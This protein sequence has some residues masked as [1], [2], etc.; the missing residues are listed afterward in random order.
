MQLITLAL[1]ATSLSTVCLA[2]PANN[3]VALEP[4][5]TYIITCIGGRC[6]DNISRPTSG[7]PEPTT[8]KI[9]TTTSK[10]P[11]PP[12]S[13][14]KPEPTPTTTT[15]KPEP[16]KST[17]T[18]KPEPP[19]TSEKPEPTPTPTKTTIKTTTKS[20]EKPT[21]TTTE[22]VGPSSTRCPVPLYYKCGGWDGGVPWAGCTVC[23]KGAKCVVQNEWYSQCVADDDSLVEEE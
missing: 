5:Q 11:E 20:A 21:K 2:A 10:K 18:K 6:T 12:K 23:V 22:E 17:T 13:S 15:K 16:P 8:S 3:N 14:T 4:R 7:V 19:K 9:T 1:L